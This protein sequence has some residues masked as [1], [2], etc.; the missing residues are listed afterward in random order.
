MTLWHRT[1]GTY[2]DYQVN[3]VSCVWHEISGQLTVTARTPYGPTQRIETMAQGMQPQQTAQFFHYP[4]DGA[5]FNSAAALYNAECVIDGVKCVGEVGYA[6]TT[7][8][9]PI[10]I[11]MGELLKVTKEKTHPPLTISA[12][13]KVTVYNDAGSVTDDFDFPWE[14][15]NITHLH[16][17]GT[18]G[19]WVDVQ[20]F[21]L[22]EKPIGAWRTF[23]SY[24]TA[25]HNGYR[26][27]VWF[28]KAHEAA[29]D[30]G[31]E[32]WML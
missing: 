29:M 22:I 1:P 17:G 26:K 13:S 19:P 28:W 27:L 5:P 14:L 23:Y 8:E 31:Y 9:P 3:K 12:T 24:V 11:M 7:H 18:F 30:D 32:W 25:M 21:A 20:H 2:E 16:P 15:R 4:G 6:K 10:A